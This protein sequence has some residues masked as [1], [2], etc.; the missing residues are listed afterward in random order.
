MFFLKELYDK[1]KRR[2]IT[3][4]DRPEC[5]HCEAM[6]DCIPHEK[7]CFEKLIV[8]RD[9]DGKIIPPT[10]E[11]KMFYGLGIMPCCGGPDFYLGPEGG[12]SINITCATCGQRWNMTAALQMIEKL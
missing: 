4:Y 3:P 6:V 11:Q 12:M 1:F 10:K 9:A 7:Q 2:Q 8:M 5:Q